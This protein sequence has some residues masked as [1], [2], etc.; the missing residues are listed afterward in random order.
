MACWSGQGLSA[1]AQG[2]SPHEP[3]LHAPALSL[4]LT[5]P[6]PGSPGYSSSLHTIRLP[7]PMSCPFPF[8]PPSML[9]PP[10]PGPFSSGILIWQVCLCSLP[11][12]TA[13]AQPPKFR[14]P[15]SPA[16]GA[17]KMNPL[18]QQG[19]WGPGQAAG[20]HRHSVLAQVP[21][22]AT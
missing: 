19:L 2:C 14:S 8:L 17:P 11:P 18:S 7:T 3:T 4:P 10:A 16:G 9:G 5:L 13:T 21:R 22:E 6:T 12:S 1:A 20:T 15:L